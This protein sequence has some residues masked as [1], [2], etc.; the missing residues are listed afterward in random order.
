MPSP[1]NENGL[2]NIRETYRSRNESRYPGGQYNIELL[3]VGGGGQG[4][5]WFGGGGGGGAGGLIYTNSII[6]NAGTCYAVTI[7]SGGAGND[8]NGISQFPGSNTTF[9]YVDGGVSLI[10]LRGGA[11]GP[12]NG[13][14]T[15]NAADQSACWGSGGGASTG[16]FPAPMC[17]GI[18]SQN[19]PVYWGGLTQFCGYGNPG[20]GACIP[21]GCPVPCIPAAPYPGCCQGGGGGAG[22]AGCP[23]ATPGCPIYPAPCGGAGGGRGGL[24]LCFSISGTQLGYAG[25]GGGNSFGD[26]YNYAFGASPASFNFPGPGCPQASRDRFA[27][28]NRGGGSGGVP[29]GVCCNHA[30]PGVVIVRYQG[31]QRG[32]GGTINTSLSPTIQTSH[33]FT[34]TGTF[35]A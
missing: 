25:G 5:G 9:C 4:G 18:G 7:G 22:G 33:V 30:G 8:V 11:G 16:G 21:G 15:G 27:C 23:G 13:P 35:Q 10:A 26:A 12:G 31:T 24:G 20:G 3:L 19:N 17:A 6:V 28:A 32:C 29:G 14:N 34:G 1:I 2:W